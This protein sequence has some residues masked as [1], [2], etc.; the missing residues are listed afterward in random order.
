MI[1]QGE[2]N[3]DRQIDRFKDRQIDRFKDRQIERWKDI[4]IYKYEDRYKMDRLIDNL[5]ICKWTDSY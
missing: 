4:Q 1:D 3:R 2:E 5:Y